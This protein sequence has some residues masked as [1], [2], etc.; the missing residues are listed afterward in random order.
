MVNHDTDKGFRKLEIIIINFDAHCNRMKNYVH[1]MESR[2][3]HSK[4][5][6][7]TQS[8]SLSN[9]LNNK[10]PMDIIL[11]SHS[12]THSNIRICNN[13]IVVGGMGSMVVGMWNSMNRLGIKNVFD[14]FDPIARI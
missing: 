1:P 3:A 11:T 9:A 6:S 12:L 4:D 10:E 8:G 13:R 5:P 14:A 7:K 2:F